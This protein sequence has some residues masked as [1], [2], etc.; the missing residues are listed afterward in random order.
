M[1]VVLLRLA[2]LHEVL[3][4]DSALRLQEKLRSLVFFAVVCFV[5]LLF[6]PTVGDRPRDG[7]EL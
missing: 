3:G 6:R 4:D 5:A 2:R 1:R 7:D